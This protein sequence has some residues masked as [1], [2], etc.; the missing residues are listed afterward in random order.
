[1]AERG[2]KEHARSPKAISI[3]LELCKACGICADLCPAS[4]FDRDDLGRPLVAR[5]EDCTTCLFCERHCPDYAIEIE[6]RRKPRPEPAGDAVAAGGSAA[7]AASGQGE[8][9][10]RRWEAVP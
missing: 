1:M 4:V 8:G 10:R 6:R 2:D 5:L 9:T 7:G 3:D